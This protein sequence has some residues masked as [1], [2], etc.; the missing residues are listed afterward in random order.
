MFKTVVKTVFLIALVALAGL[1]GC[2]VYSFNPRGKAS[3]E[4]ISVQRFDNQT[5]EY[6]LSDRITDEIID[7]FIADG[8]FKVL[9]ESGAEAILVGTLTRYDRRPNTYDQNDQVTQYRVEMDFLITMK[10]PADGSD[11]WSERLNPIGIYDIDDE[12]EEEGQQRAIALL[13]ENIINKS[14]KSW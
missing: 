11:I 8:T 5:V 12:T 7:A 4:S 13:I 2:G 1:S 9:P 10:N 6:G 3:F 14:T